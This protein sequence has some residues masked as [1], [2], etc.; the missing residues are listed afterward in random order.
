MHQACEQILALAE[1][2]WPE[3]HAVPVL[4]VEGEDGELVVVARSQ[5]QLETREVRRTD[6]SQKT[7]LRV[8]HR[9]TARDGRQRLCQGRQTFGPLVAVSAVEAHLTA[10]LDHLQAVSV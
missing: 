10:Y 5:S 7:Q 4:E 1:R 8:D 2:Q 9:G 3:I 6:A